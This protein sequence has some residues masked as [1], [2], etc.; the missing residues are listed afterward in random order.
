[1]PFP[2][3]GVVP[4][5]GSMEPTIHCARR[6]DRTCQAPTADLLLEEESGPRF[7]HR[8][9]I[10]SFTD[11]PAAA[12][13]CS[14]GSGGVIKRVLAVGGDRVRERDGVISLNGHV[15]AEPY[16]PRGERGH[17]S[18]SWDVPR[19]FL[20]VAGDDRA[21]SCDSRYWGPL[22]ES[23]VDGRIVEIVRPGSGGSDA[24]GPP[25][26]HVAHPFHA[27][28]LGDAT[29]EPTIHCAHPGVLCRARRPDLL[30]VEYAGARSIQRGDIVVFL[31]P[32]AAGPYCGRGLAVERVI[33]LPGERVTERSGFVFVDGRRLDEPYISARQRD[34]RSGAWIVPGGAYLVLGDART[35]A[36]DSRLWGPLPTAAVRGRVV[37]I[38]RPPA[39]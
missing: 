37:E 7:V 19:G 21:V 6:V 4:V 25:L 27:L 18:G 38:I 35:R 12:R 32:P 26:V 22:N 23:R 16:V 20:F 28:L 29:M 1:V 8:G 39:R 5:S 36:C 30:L 33:G 2:Y 17:H 31:L 14:P 13:Y 15:L 34:D 24:V 9:D 3:L 10:V 11:P